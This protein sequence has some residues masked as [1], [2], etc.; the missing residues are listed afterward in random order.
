MTGH[1]WGHAYTEYT[2]GL[3]YEWQSGALNESYS[4]IWGETIDRING[5]DA[6]PFPNG[7]RERR[8]L[9]DVLRHSASDPDDH[10][11]QRGRHAIQLSSRPSSRRC[12]ST[13]GPTD[14]AIAVTAPP[15]QP[16]GACGAVSGVSG[17]IAIV[18]WTLLADGVTN[19]CGSVGPLHERPERRRDRRH[20]RGSRQQA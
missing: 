7:P 20:L 14:M 5:R 18:D 17:K 6:F 4:D 11:R 10:R 13:V 8:R 15:A 19:E 16:T 1:E 9:L 12:L 3:I 2:H